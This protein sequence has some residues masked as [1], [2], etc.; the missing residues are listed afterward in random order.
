MTLRKSDDNGNWKRKYYIA[1]CRE[2]A[3]EET[4]DK[5]KLI[6]WFISCPNTDVTFCWDYARS[7]CM[8]RVFVLFV[9]DFVQFYGEIFGCLMVK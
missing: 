5:M 6:V 1:L 3:L 9:K 2:L 7:T 8:A 4:A